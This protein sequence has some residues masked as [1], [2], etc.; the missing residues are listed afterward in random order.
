[1]KSADTLRHDASSHYHLSATIFLC[2]EGVFRPIAITSPPPYNFAA[3][4]CENIVLH[5][6]GEDYAAPFRKIPVWAGYSPGEPGISVSSGE[7]GYFLFAID[8]KVLMLECTAYRRNRNVFVEL[9]VEVG[10][11]A[12]HLPIDEADE[13]SFIPWSRNMWTTAL[14]SGCRWLYFSWCFTVLRLTF[15]QYS[16]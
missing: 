11:V 12:C 16:F 7:I 1:M 4:W 6:V 3:V 5:L 15:F 13:M 9:V 10:C 8:S 2:L 14:G